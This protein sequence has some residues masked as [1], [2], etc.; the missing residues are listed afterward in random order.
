VTGQRSVAILARKVNS[1]A[2]HLDRD[3]VRGSGVMCATSLRIK[4]DTAHLRK[5]RSHCTKLQK[6]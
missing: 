6:D 1:A 2:L 5:S 4:V 3:D